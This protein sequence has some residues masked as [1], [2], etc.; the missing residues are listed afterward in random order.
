MN[1]NLVFCKDGVLRVFCA[2]SKVPLP[3]KFLQENHKTK[4]NDLAFMA[5]WWEEDVSFEKGTTVGSFL[6]CLEPWQEFWKDLIAKDVPAYIAE[7]RRPI[8]VKKYD[9]EEERKN[10]R[11][12]DWIKLYFVTELSTSVHFEP[13]E[14][15][16][17]FSAWLNSNKKVQFDGMWDIDSHCCLSGY[18]FGEVEQY[19]IDHTSMSELANVPFVLSNENITYVQDHYVNKYLGKKSKLINP[20]AFGLRKLDE[21]Q[22]SGF[23]YILGYKK[24][25]LR[26][27]VE[28]FFWWFAS[29][30]ERREEFTESLKES[31]KEL[32]ETLKNEKI[33]EGKTKE[34]EKELTKE[35]T[36]IKGDL[37]IKIAPGAFDGISERY[38]AEQNYWT[39]Q[40]KLFKATPNKQVVRIGKIEKA[41][42]LE[43]RVFAS[44]VKKENY[45]TEFLDKLSL[46]DEDSGK[47]KDNED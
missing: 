25:N 36:G 2:G 35:D 47:G 5:R 28:A 7:S 11:P 23:N 15:G 45:Q 24:F 18:H 9:S 34:D 1:F 20:E 29:N 33:K 31:V 38:D 16:E 6:R 27:V 42:P 13:R 46:Q 22:E 39:N 21:D 8:I 17:R 26:S 4:N 40:V 19:S 41:T 43:N 14:K 3:L 44:I 30:P 12:L 10:D 32:D 37:K